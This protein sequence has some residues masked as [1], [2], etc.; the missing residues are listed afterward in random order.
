VWDRIRLHAAGDAS[1]P[2]DRAGWRKLL[3]AGMATVLTAWLHSDRRIIP[4]MVTPSNVVVPDPDWR[5]DRLVISLGGWKPYTGP[6]SLVRPLLKNFLRLPASHFPGC[7]PLLDDAW[8]L[9]A[10][11]EALGQTPAHAFLMELAADLAREDLAEAGPGFAAQVAAFAA[12]L[13]AGYRVSLGLESAVERFR[14]WRAAN[15]GAASGAS[16][17]QIEALARLYHLDDLGEPM[18]FALFARTYFARSG[19][20]VGNAFARLQSRL[21]SDP[22][23][24]AAQTVELSDLQSLFTAADD[25]LAFSRL[26]F[27]HAAP[28][29][30]PQVATVGDRDHRH[31]VLQT[32]LADHQGVAY[33]CLEPRSAAEVGKLYRLFLECGFALTI[34]PRDRHL[35]LLDAREQVI[36]GIVHRPDT[37]AEPHLEG[38]VVARTLR[39]RGLARALID[40]F[41]HRMAAEGH[42]LVRTHYSLREFFQRQGFDVDRKW[43]GFVR[44]LR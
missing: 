29:H 31:V 39:G 4:G 8:V 43:G 37:G 35:V 38:V 16:I 5:Q 11:A 28:E 10:I 2:L 12:T 36:G 18:R 3:V 1:R 25:R 13:A 20:E 34:S 24:R 26:A 23:L 7:G 40:D 32:V 15:P 33:V 41:C 19:P 6:L 21:F 30:Q 9:E 27:P 44:R 22:Q 14:D 42:T 17:D